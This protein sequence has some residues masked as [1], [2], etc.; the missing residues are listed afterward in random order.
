MLFPIGPCTKRIKHIKGKDALYLI[1][2]FYLRS[3]YEDRNSLEQDR[4]FYVPW[5][6]KIIFW[7]EHNSVLCCRKKIELKFQFLF[8]GNRK[9]LFI[10]QGTNFSYLLAQVILLRLEQNK[11]HSKA[12]LKNMFQLIIHISSFFFKVKHL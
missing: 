1:D 11:S 5:L 6:L 4:L 7:L 8:V 10:P 9:N 2:N 3:L 12:W